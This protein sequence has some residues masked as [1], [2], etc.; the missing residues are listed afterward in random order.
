MQQPITT[1]FGPRTAASLAVLAALVVAAAPAAV[2]PAAFANASASGMST[3]VAGPLRI[4]TSR[5]LQCQVYRSGWTARAYFTA[6]GN[7]MG[8][9][10]DGACGT[11]LQYGGTTYGSAHQFPG[12]TF[13]PALTNFE[14]YAQGRINLSTYQCIRTKVG[15]GAKFT[16]RQTD[17]Y[18]PGET[19]FRT[20]VTVSNLTTSPQT[21][22]IV[23]AVDCFVRGSDSGNGTSTGANRVYCTRNNSLSTA[24]DQSEGLVVTAA[25]SDAV[26][27]FMEATP[28]SIWGRVNAPF[29]TNGVTIGNHDNAMGLSVKVGV[30]GND[31]V[32]VS[33]RSTF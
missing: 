23:R 19:H 11:F 14:P 33:F 2:P 18:T 21:F 16:V 25:P 1:R 24:A 26:V 3:T 31:S 28:G 22:R 4:Y 12:T 15:A 8:N 30:E 29:F 5:Q 20:T 27:R 6:N 7:Q 32:I 13:S 9:P 17:C 10:Y